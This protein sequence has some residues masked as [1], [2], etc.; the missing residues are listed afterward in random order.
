[1]SMRR[2]EN[3]ANMGDAALALADVAYNL[4]KIPLHAAER[5][6]G[7]RRLAAEGAGVRARARSVLER[8]AED[9]VDWLLAG[10]LPDAVARSAIEHQVAERIAAELVESLDLELAVTAALDNETTER[11]VQAVLVSPAMQRTIEYV[12]SSP[13]VRAALTAQSTGLAEEMVS[14]VRTRAETFDDVAERTVRG[15]LRR[16]R[17]A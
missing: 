16:P 9:A 10:R 14:G 1:M 2:V 4:A 13:E 6:P 7:M 8:R 3:R 12:A 5:L 15:W 17:P 11:L